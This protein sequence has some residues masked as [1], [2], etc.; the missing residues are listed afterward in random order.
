MISIQ[1]IVT[2]QTLGTLDFTVFF[3][4]PGH[5]SENQGSKEGV[6]MESL[7]RS[8]GRLARTIFPVFFFEA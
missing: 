6:A 8:L 7:K 5:V 2:S 4:F 3:G 1:Q